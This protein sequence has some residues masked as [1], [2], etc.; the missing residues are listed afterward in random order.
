MVGT[1]VDA[2]DTFED[3][4]EEDFE[5]ETVMEFSD[6]AL[7]LMDQTLIGL[8][9]EFGNSQEFCVLDVINHKGNDYLILI[10]AEDEEDEMSEVTILRQVEDDEDDELC[11][12]DAV[13][14]E[15]EIHEV[16][17]LFKKR[18]AE[19]YNFVDLN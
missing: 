18:N 7:E 13:E 14:D 8:T 4:F 5:P 1:M 10:D 16:F 6:D 9:D 17:S 3:T 19:L 12:Y 15:D 11:S 2:Y